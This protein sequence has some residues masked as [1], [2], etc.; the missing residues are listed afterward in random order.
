MVKITRLLF[1]AQNTP[2]HVAANKGYQKIVEIL[3]DRGANV[4]SKFG[5]KKVGRSENFVYSYTWLAPCVN[6]LPSTL[7]VHEFLQMPNFYFYTL[8]FRELHSIW[9]PTMDTMRQSSTYLIKV[10]IQRL[11]I[12]MAEIAFT[13][14]SRPITSKSTLL[15]HLRFCIICG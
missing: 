1:Y 11:K 9:H 10:Q 4:Q 7:L 12:R 14:Q 15:L 6:H 2:L 5:S 3:V 13:W 8:Y